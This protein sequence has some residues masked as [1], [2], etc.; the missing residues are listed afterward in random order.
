MNMILGG[1][2]LGIYFIVRW[3]IK[4]YLF[5][6]RFILIFIWSA[7]CGSS[8]LYLDWTENVYFKKRFYKFWVLLTYGVWGVYPIFFAPRYLFLTVPVATLFVLSSLRNVKICESCGSI[9]RFRFLIRETRKSCSVCE[10]EF[11][12]EAKKR[13]MSNL[14]AV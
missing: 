2:I 7:L 13:E 4:G 5:D 8:W 14:H 10:I 6:R 11:I 3:Y 1:L 12:D 9:V